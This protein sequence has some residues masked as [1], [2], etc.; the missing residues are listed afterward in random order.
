M[1]REGREDYF[2]SYAE[3]GVSGES[4]LNSTPSTRRRN[5]MPSNMTYRTTPTSGTDLPSAVSSIKPDL[6]NSDWNLGRGLEHCHSPSR[7]DLGDLIY[8]MESTDQ[9][10]KDR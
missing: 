6:Y 7:E 3:S 8:A 9:T 5:T 4:S 2:E 1:S 10:A